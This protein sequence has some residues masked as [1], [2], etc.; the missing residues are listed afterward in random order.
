[1]GAGPN[2]RAAPGCYTA[3]GP[4]AILLESTVEMRFAGPA[5]AHPAG[6]GDQS[7]YYRVCFGRVK[8]ASPF[9]DRRSMHVGR[10]D[11]P[12]RRRQPKP[13]R[14]S[15]QYG[16]VKSRIVSVGTYRDI[17]RG[18]LRVLFVFAVSIICGRTVVF[19]SRRHL[20]YSS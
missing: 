3:T 12:D 7:P 16:P 17:A 18:G 1:M 2:C 11:M 14:L 6:E 20:E 15:F 9:Q 5:S 4:N 13:C 8:P 10:A 19:E